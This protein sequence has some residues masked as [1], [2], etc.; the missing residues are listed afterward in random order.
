MNKCSNCGE[1]NRDDL[2]SCGN[3]GEEMFRG[4]EDLR[5]LKDKNNQRNKGVEE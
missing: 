5:E 4:N 1:L 3:C 2:D